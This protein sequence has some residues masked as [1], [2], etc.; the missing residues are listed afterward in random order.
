MDGMWAISEGERTLGY[1]VVHFD[2]LGNYT[3]TSGRIIPTILEKRWGIFSNWA[4]AH[5]AV[6]YGQTWN[7]P[8]AG[9]C[10]I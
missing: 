7:C 1:G 3:L 10:V 6:F 2:G 4:T 8:F 5:F 9:G